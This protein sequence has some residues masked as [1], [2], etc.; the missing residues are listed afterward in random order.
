MFGEKG[1][2]AVPGELGAFRI[3]VRPFFVE[4]G[5]A[6]IIPVGLKRDFA[7]FELGFQG[8]RALRAEGLVLLRKV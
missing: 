6:G 5:V 4:K 7:F 1:D 2:G 8:A 3:I